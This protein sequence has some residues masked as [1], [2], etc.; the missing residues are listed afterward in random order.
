MP[1]KLHGTPLSHFTRK[2]RILLAELGVQY[3]MA[4]T[5]SL[6]ADSPAGFGDNPLMRIPTLVVGDRIVVDSD[7][8]ARVIVDTYDTS[9]WFG[10]KT[11][12][13]MLLN[14]LAVANGIM[15][16]AVSRILAKRGG[17]EDVDSVAYFR[18]LLTAM[19]SGLA[20]L[21]TNIALDAPLTWADIA[22]ICMWGHTNHFKAVPELERYGRIAQRVAQF[23]DRPSVTA[24]A[25]E[26]AFAEA[27]AAGWKPPS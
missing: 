13:P 26:A 16:N 12:D 6:L 7:H 3:E 15:A 5:S 23:A 17:F 11:G 8:I 20:W 9:D 1:L 25:P 10:V 18:K 14:R 21:D 27:K 24:T 22:L 4:W 19:Q 2:V